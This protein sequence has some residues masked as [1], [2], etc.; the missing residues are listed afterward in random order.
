ME[1]R[2]PPAPIIS[3]CSRSP[4]SQTGVSLPVAV[5]VDGTR[6][7]LEHI[8]ASTLATGLSCSRELMAR[9]VMVVTS[10]SRLHPSVKGLVGAELHNGESQRVHL[11]LRVLN[12]VAKD[13]SNAGRPALA[14]HL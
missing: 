7:S 9:I 5:V 12:R 8:L 3:G 14:F 4:Q 1:G 10:E 13:V 6:E 2:S 11:N